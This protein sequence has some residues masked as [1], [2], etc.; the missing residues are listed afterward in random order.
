[1][2]DNDDVGREIAP[3]RATPTGELCQNHCAEGVTPARE[4]TVVGTDDP[5]PNP[6]QPLPSPSP[7]PASTSAP[8]VPDAPARDE[9]SVVRNGES[10]PTDR[11]STPDNKEEER[12]CPATTEIPISPSG[13]DDARTPTP[14]GCAC[15][16]GGTPPTVHQEEIEKPPCR[17]GNESASES[18]LTSEAASSSSSA[19][20]SASASTLESV[21]ESTAMSGC[22]ENDKSTQGEVQRPNEPASKPLYCGPTIQSESVSSQPEVQKSA[23]VLTTNQNTTAKAGTTLHQLNSVW[24]VWYSNLGKLTTQQQQQQQQQ[25]M[26]LQMQQY[27]E[28]PNSPQVRRKNMYEQNLLKLGGFSTVESFAKHYMYLKRP[29]ELLN[30]SNYFAFKG[31]TKPMWENFPQGG[32][33]IVKVVKNSSEINSFWEE[34]L[35]AAIGEQLDDTVVGVVLS[36]RKA[37]AVLSV[38]VTGEHSEIHPQIRDKLMDLFHLAGSTEQVQYKPHCTSIRD[39]STDIDNGSTSSG[40]ASNRPLL[41]EGHTRAL[42]N[43]LLMAE[44]PQV[45]NKQHANSQSTRGSSLAEILVA[46]KR[47]FTKRTEQLTAALALSV[48]LLTAIRLLPKQQPTTQPQPTRRNQQA[49]SQ[50]MSPSLS[51]LVGLF[52]VQQGTTRTPLLLFHRIT[53]FYLLADL[54]KPENTPPAQAT[55]TSPTQAVGHPG[56]FWFVLQEAFDLLDQSS[57]ERTFLIQL[58]SNVVSPEKTPS[59]YAALLTAT[60]VAQQNEAIAAI[61]KVLQEQQPMDAFGTIFR[62]IGVPSPQILLRRQDQPSEE[63]QCISPRSGGTQQPHPLSDFLSS[64]TVQSF[65]PK[66]IRPPP[67]LFPVTHDELTWLDIEPPV[68]LFANRFMSTPRFNQEAVELVTTAFKSTLTQQQLELVMSE[69]DRDE[70]FV[71]HCNVTP[72]QLPMLVDNNPLIAIEVLLKLMSSSQITDYFSVLVNM[73]MSLHSM[74]VVNRLTTAV[75]LPKEFVHLYISNCIKKCMNT[76]DKSMQNRSV[77]LVCVFLQS[78]IRN[79]VINSHDLFLEIQQ[80]C[81]EFAKIREA[82]MLFKALREVD[83]PGPSSTSTSNTTVNSTPSMP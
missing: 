76:Q 42:T 25:Q 78:L 11:G 75:E 4:T 48:A 54:S 23:A 8:C 64:I 73:D 33:F 19:S 32:C 70:K 83:S 43:I 26:Q 28:I 74:E 72:K 67:N 77:R 7:S 38:W 5:L 71:Y 31:T 66:F 44:P 12:A 35:F 15:E 60:P 45:T 39:Q 20:A 61:R 2:N 30:N 3:E 17:F 34:L 58:A 1:M 27:F 59:E 81:I 50:P 36:I 69:F 63:R 22:N 41:S 47:S 37:F 80:F 14:T 13:P 18:S 51:L 52:N 6:V 21:S 57:P 62:R 46:F 53:S 24:T 55:S 68:E 29:S 65:D 82:T 16:T 49:S 10:N 40:A 9:A 56:M 79:S